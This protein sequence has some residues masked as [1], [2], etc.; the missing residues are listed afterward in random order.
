MEKPEKGEKAE[1][2]EKG[3]KAERTEKGE[4]A[5]KGEK[6]SEK[7]GTVAAA[8]AVRAL[9]VTLPEGATLDDYRLR[10]AQEHRLWRYEEDLREIERLTA[11][12][13]EQRERSLAAFVERTAAAIE[14]AVAAQSREAPTDKKVHPLFLS[15]IQLSTF[16][17][18]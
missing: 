6:S 1:K 15:R 14:A 11:R 12:V 5:E 7:A 3:E 9:A 17:H 16:I 4:K 18:S 2:P 10:S 8:A 13:K